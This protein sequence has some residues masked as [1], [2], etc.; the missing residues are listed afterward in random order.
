MGAGSWHARMVLPW[1][2]GLGVAALVALIALDLPRHL[3]TDDARE[4][5]E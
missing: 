5:V 3:A 2:A 4:T 1:L